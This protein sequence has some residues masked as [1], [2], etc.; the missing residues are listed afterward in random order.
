MERLADLYL[1]STTYEKDDIG[2]EKAVEVERGPFC[3]SVNGISRQEWTAAG[4]QGLQ[5]LCMCKMSDSI[6]YQGEKIAKISGCPDIPEGR[7][8]IYRPFPTNDGGIE[9]Y[10]REDAGS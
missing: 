5:P 6:D 8:S 9:L 4:Q 7:Y 3:V 2:Q 1:I 10:I